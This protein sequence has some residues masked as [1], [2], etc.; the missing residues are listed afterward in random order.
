[1]SRS[2]DTTQ[3]NNLNMAQHENLEIAKTDND[4]LAVIA[5]PRGPVV[6]WVPM[7]L[8]APDKPGRYLVTEDFGEMEEGVATRCV[9][10]MYW[11]GSTFSAGGYRRVIAWA[12]PVRVWEG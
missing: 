7:S 4:H 2:V 8:R 11:D 9:N 10:V 12:Y 6:D 3:R 1:M 5:I